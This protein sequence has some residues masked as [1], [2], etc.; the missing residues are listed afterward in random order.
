MKI[1][2][3]KQEVEFIL[4]SLTAAQRADV[5]RGGSRD[6]DFED[7]HDSIEQKLKLLLETEIEQRVDELLEKGA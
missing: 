3:S 6:F 2:L 1:E 5:M 7:K 4:K